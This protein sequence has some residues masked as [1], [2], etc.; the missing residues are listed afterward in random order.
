MA[1]SY[2]DKFQEN[3]CLSENS[4]RAWDFWNKEYFPLS[5]FLK[6][7]K[8]QDFMDQAQQFFYNTSQ[9]SSFPVSPRAMTADPWLE[10]YKSKTKK[11]RFRAQSTD[12]WVSEIHGSGTND[13]WIESY[14]HKLS[15]EKDRS[16]KALWVGENEL[17]KKKCNLN[18]DHLILGCW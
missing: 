2:D 4:R 6:N 9:D 15:I 16:E 7:S 11:S 12:P 1:G 3:L 17:S 5:S 14:Y 18:L 13:I 8:Y 10:S